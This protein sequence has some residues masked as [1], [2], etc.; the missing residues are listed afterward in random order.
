MVLRDSLWMVATGILIG[1]PC[2]YAVGR[3]LQTALFGLQPLDIPTTALSFAA[4]LGV[5][6]GA[7]L[8]PARR[9]AST[10][11]VVALRVE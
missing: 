11:P 1:L 6:L 5:A 2:A 4:L 3:F 10:D 7:A 8:I 9:A